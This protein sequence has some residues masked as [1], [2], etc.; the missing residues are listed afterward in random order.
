MS[1]TLLVAVNDILE[2]A[3]IVHGAS[4]A[5][6]SF[7]DSS[8]QTFIDRAIRALNRALEEIYSR[9]DRHLPQQT[10]TGTLT[11]VTDDRD[12]A[13]ASDLVVL[14]WPLR[15]ETSGHY[16]YQ[17]PGDEPYWGLIKSQRIPADYTGQPNYGAIR[18][19]DG[20]LYLDRIPTANENGDAY[21]YQYEKDVSLSATTDTFPVTDEVYRILQRAAFEEW[22]RLSR[23]DYS[24]KVY[25]ESLGQAARRMRQVPSYPS[26]SPQHGPEPVSRDGIPDPFEA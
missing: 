17:F 23:R 3:G 4:G 8:R 6:T 2:D 19:S 20:Q 7:T 14:R 24:E 15:N 16:I 22:K 13:L 21:E 26:Y 11:L 5:I 12:Y 18:T 10:G 25:N 1:T 9:S